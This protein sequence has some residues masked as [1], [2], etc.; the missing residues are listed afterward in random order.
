MNFTMKLSRKITANAPISIRLIKQAM[1][2]TYELDL[3]AAMQF[4]TNGVMECHDNA[5]FLE[6]VRAF[7]EKRAPVY[8]GK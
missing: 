8:R 3:A 4:E 5:D 1:Q 7:V 6:G 2:K